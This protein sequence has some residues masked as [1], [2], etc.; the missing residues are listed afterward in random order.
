MAAQTQLEFLDCVAVD[1]VARELF[2]ATNSLLTGKN[3]GNF[4]RMLRRRLGQTMVMQRF[5]GKLSSQAKSEQGISWERIGNGNSLIPRSPVFVAAKLAVTNL[6]N[7][8]FKFMTH[9]VV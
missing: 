3:T 6:N 2:S 1:A 4:L 8:L 7:A 9:G 5:G